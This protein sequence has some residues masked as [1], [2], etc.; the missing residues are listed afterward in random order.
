MYLRSIFSFKNYRT[1]LKHFY[2]VRKSQDEGYSF[3][4][5][6]RDAG[7]QSANY[8]KLVMD[9]KKNLT[10]TNIHRFAEA[11]KL[12]AHELEYFETLVLV[13]QAKT[14]PERNFYVER[15]SRFAPPQATTTKV[16]SSSKAL[17]SRWYWPAMLLWLDGRSE[18]NAAELASKI[19]R[20]SLREAHNCIKMLIDNDAL[21]LSSGKFTLTGSYVYLHDT[22][23]SNPVQMNFV[24]EQLQL[25]YDAFRRHYRTHAKFFCHT[26]RINEEDRPL[27]IEKFKKFLDD[28][29]ALSDQMPGSDI[30]QIN[31]QMF[32][33]PLDD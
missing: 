31:S 21:I 5:F 25:S 2:E 6:S 27:Y 15:L 10:I 30:F 29:T 24:E 17:I 12:S 18:S 1:F 33:I 16:Y 26:L 20:I 4:Q 11:L 28:I 3:H 7:L 32:R 9:G 8:L 23:S 13:D 22:F 14:K 19:F